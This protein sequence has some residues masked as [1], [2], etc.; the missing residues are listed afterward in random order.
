ML[1][2]PV[3]TRVGRE[4]LTVCGECWVF[5]R[6]A[7]YTVCSVHG[8]VCVFVCECVYVW[9]RGQSFCPFTHAPLGF[10][11]LSYQCVQPPSIH[12]NN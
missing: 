2:L 12:S 9:I 10:S 7:M 11:F 6:D 1:G 4:C 5:V 8:S 3:S